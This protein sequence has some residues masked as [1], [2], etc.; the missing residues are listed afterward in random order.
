MALSLYETNG[1]CVPLLASILGIDVVSV[2]VVV[3]VVVIMDDA[4]IA[5]TLIAIS[6]LKE[7][8][9]SSVAATRDGG[10]GA[11][12]RR[13]F[14]REYEMGYSALSMYVELTDSQDYTSEPYIIAS[15]G[16]R[17]FAGL[18]PRERN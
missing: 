13:Y 15:L 5:F 2:V 6:S 12:E 18:L 17:E 9:C 8:R 4:P 3:V 16:R 1:D 14:R 10:G 7:R 11:G